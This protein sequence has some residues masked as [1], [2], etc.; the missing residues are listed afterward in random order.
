MLH[1]QSSIYFYNHLFYTCTVLQI[2][3]A[4]KFSFEM[5]TG[6]RCYHMSFNSSSFCLSFYAFCV[7]HSQVFNVS[8]IVLFLLFALDSAK[9]MNALLIM[10]FCSVETILNSIQ[11]STEIPLIYIQLRMKFQTLFMFWQMHKWPGKL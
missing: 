4:T 7:C 2:W 11:K 10:L 5:V 6:K 8:L 1:L 3:P 9:P